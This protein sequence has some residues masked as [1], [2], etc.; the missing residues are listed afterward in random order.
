MKKISPLIAAAFLVLFVVAMIV[1]AFIDQELFRAMGYAL[2]NIV[3]G[4]AGYYFGTSQSSATKDAVIAKSLS[5]SA[6]KGG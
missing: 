6:P 2:V 3:V 4:L 5:S 1:A